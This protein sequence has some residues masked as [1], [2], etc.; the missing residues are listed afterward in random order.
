MKT[1]LSSIIVC[2]V[3]VSINSQV[4]QIN[5]EEYHTVKT[6]NSGE[7]V[8]IFDFNRTNGLHLPL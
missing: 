5:F 4:N 7:T 3:A 8:A 2:L 1:I 6:D